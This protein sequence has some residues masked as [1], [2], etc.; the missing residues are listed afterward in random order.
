[1]ADNW[2]L[3]GT[4]FESCNCDAACPCVFLSDPTEG[5]CKVVVAWHIDSGK[6]GDVG[7]DGL[8][9]ALAA[10]APGNMMQVKWKVALYLD[11]KANEAQ[12]GALT[13]IF[14]GQAGGHPA[15]LGSF[16]G[17]VLGVKAV[18]IEYKADG[19]A[20]SLSLG[21]VGEMAVEGI[22]GQGGAPIT[23]S[24]HPLCI[25]PGEPAT[26]GKSKK[27]SY[28]DHGMTWE[29]TGKNAFYSPFA[30]QGP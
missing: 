17:E 14:A 11:A 5:E 7:L 30:Y 18:P 15:V 19:K 23:V 22:G 6:S 13:Q 28:K 20:R 29:F 1:M 16:V 2:N 26:V 3:K 24:N 10:H 27:L 21:G 9:V 8:N 4:Y 12:Q 25:A